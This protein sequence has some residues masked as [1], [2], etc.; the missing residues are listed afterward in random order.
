MDLAAGR[1]DRAVFAAWRA[2]TVQ[3]KL[4]NLVARPLPGP[5]LRASLVLWRSTVRR[6]A[7]VERLQRILARP[8]DRRR[9][10]AAWRAVSLRRRQRHL[11]AGRLERLQA[12][13]VA[14]FSSWRAE[15]SRQQPGSSPGPVLV[16]PRMERQCKEKAAT[17]LQRQRLRGAQGLRW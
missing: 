10:F 4:L 6:G 3:R 9:A 2:A 13:P 15:T 5:A 12:A 17:C 1:G 8:G 7:H 16:A 11:Q 14:A